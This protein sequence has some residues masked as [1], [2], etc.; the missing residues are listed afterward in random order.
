M[1]SSRCHKKGFG[2][3]GQAFFGRFMTGFL[4]FY[5]SRITAEKIGSSFIQQLGDLSVFNRALANHCLE[6]ARIVRDFA[7]QWYSKTQY[8]RGVSLDNTAGFVAVALSKLQEELRHQHRHMDH[9]RGRS[10]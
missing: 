8:E 5:L 1:V 2:E 9:S 4:N 10:V 7:G 3:L 6:S